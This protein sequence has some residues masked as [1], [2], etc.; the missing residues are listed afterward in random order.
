M[1]R[2]LFSSHNW[3]SKYMFMPN[4]AFVV[5]VWTRYNEANWSQK[6]FGKQFKWHINKLKVKNRIQYFEIYSKLSSGYILIWLLRKS[7]HTPCN[8]NICRLTY[9]T[10]ALQP[11]KLRG[12]LTSLPHTVK[13]Y[14]DSMK[15]T[16]LLTWDKDCLIFH[17][18]LIS[19][20][21]SKINTLDSIRTRLCSVST[22]KS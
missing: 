5:T 7:K 16:I 20:L 15:N 13:R 19:T 12:F 11:I 17:V 9:R 1:S 10:R 2:N 3:F 14:T 4:R 21:T 6:C 18:L 8:R 22:I